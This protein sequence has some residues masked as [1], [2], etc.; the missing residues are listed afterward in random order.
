METPSDRVLYGCVYWNSPICSD[1]DFIMHLHSTKKA[2]VEC[3]K[4][5]DIEELEVVD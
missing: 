2:A 5:D 3:G 4:G 1:G